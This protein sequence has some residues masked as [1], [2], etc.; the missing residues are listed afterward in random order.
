MSATGSSTRVRHAYLRQGRADVLAHRGASV[1]HPPG[2]TW[3]A[4]E[5]ALTLGA[6]HIETDVQLS[7]DGRVVVYHD[8]RLDDATTGSGTVADHPWAHLRT[9]RYCVDGEPTDEGLVLLDDLLV[10]WPSVYF[11]ID[12]KVDEAVDPVV[13]ILTA[14]DAVDRVCVAAFGWR[15][16]RRLRRRLGPGWCSAF[17]RAEIA[18]ARLASWLRLPVPRV[19]DV[20]QVP[21]EFRHVTIVDRRFVEG[22]H[23]S[24]VAVHVWT[25]NQPDEIR[26]LTDLGVDAVITDRP[27]RALTTS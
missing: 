13:E 12:V 23:R 6:D 14:C 5:R 22:C 24:G 18:A 10:R 17:A 16:I 15:R 1:E 19:G 20:V 8:E 21:P 25:I 11:N 2:N 27:E 3:A 7:S 9:L 26:R 4:F